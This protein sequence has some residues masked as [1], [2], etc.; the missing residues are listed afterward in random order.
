VAVAVGRPELNFDA[1]CTAVLETLAQLHLEGDEPL[2]KAPTR[3]EGTVERAVF[4]AM[5]DLLRR[6]LQK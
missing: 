5:H 2:G 1:T 3:D 6:D 4:E